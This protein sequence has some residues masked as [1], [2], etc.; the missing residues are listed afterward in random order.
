[1][2]LGALSGALLYLLLRV[3]VKRRSAAIV[4][5]VL[6]LSESLLFSQSRIA[7]PDVYTLFFVLAGYLALAAVLTRASPSLR[8]PWVLL[9]FPA[10]G[11]LLGLAASTKWTGVFA[12]GGALL[13]LLLVVPRTRWFA[14]LAAAIAS[15][16]LAGVAASGVNPDPTFAV[17]VGVVTA[18]LM[19][20]VLRWE[21]QPRRGAHVSGRVLAFALAAVPIAA[22]VVYVLMYVPFL[23]LDAGSPQLIAGWPPDHHGQTLLALQQQMF[24]Y[25][26]NL[27]VTHGAGSPWWSWPL[28]LKPLWAY[29]EFFRI[30]AAG[31]L[32]PANPVILWLGVV[33]V[34]WGVLTLTRRFQ[35]GHPAAGGGVHGAVAAMGRDRTGRLLLS[36]HDGDA[37]PRW[38]A[39]HRTRAAADRNARAAL[40]RDAGR[41]RS[42]RSACPSSSGSRRRH[43]ATRSRR[44]R[45]RA[46][47]TGRWQ[48]AVPVA[49]LVIALALVLTTCALA[50][51]WLRRWDSTAWRDRDRRGGLVRAVVGSVA[52]VVAVAAAVT[53][54][55][56]L[57][58]VRSGQLVVAS[59][60]LAAVA[61]G[62]GRGSHHRGHPAGAI[63]PAIR[64]G[65]P[66]R[67]VPGVRAAPADRSWRYQC[68][69]SWSSPTNP[70]CRPGTPRSSS[71]AARAASSPALTWIGVPCVVVAGVACVDDQE[72]RQSPGRAG[73][74]IRACRARVRTTSRSP[75]EATGPRRRT[76]WVDLPADGIRRERESRYQSRCPSR[77]RCCC[78]TGSWR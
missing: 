4:G 73:E 7:T 47:C 8:S 76:L 43:S 14:V 3:I 15:G 28:L 66:D 51:W 56:R 55:V 69:P 11:V 67:R 53:L 30:D 18:V 57:E 32:M 17:V 2:L 19:W 35:A 44:T 40:A 72:A 48:I 33:A 31:I 68:L 5:A 58:P 20:W 74:R 9:G 10:V 37:V 21:R 42:W 38:A 71:S 75:R 34:G 12:I 46:I 29:L 65:H 52:I 45:A 70:C 24:S 50:A 6:F 23:F 16:V 27:T 25:H 22:A 1:M 63:E 26:S 41:P 62:R 39:G 54:I 61:R 78:R 49:S 36:L 60:T 59:P 13:F 77:S 64:G